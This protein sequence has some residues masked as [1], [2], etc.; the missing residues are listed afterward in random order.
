[1]N[2]LSSSTVDNNLAD[3]FEIVRYQMDKV[4]LRRNVF[5]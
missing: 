1:L 5:R 4:D 3:W 2:A